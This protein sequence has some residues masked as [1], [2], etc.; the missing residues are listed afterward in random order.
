M[1]CKLIAE[2]L[3]WYL[4]GTLAP[5]AQ[6]QT[7]AHLARCP[8]C[9]RELQATVEAVH[10][11]SQHAPEEA[12]LDYAFNQPLAA[13]QR[14]LLERHLATCAACAEQLE[15][16]RESCR[17][18]EIEVARADQVAAP[19][20]APVADL[21]AAR[22]ARARPLRGWQYGALAASLLGCIALGGW[23]WHWQQARQSAQ[24]LASLTGQQRELQERLASLEAEN[25]QLRQPEPQ[26]PEPRAQQELAQLRARVRE[27]SVPQLN[28]V[29]LD[30][31]P[32]EMA[33]RGQSSAVN[34]LRIPAR[35]SALTLLLN[36]QSQQAARSYSLE[37]LDAQQR[38]IAS[39]A[40]LARQATGDY[41][42][43]LPAALL[44]PGR[45]TFNVYGQIAG[46]RV[47]VDSYQ[48]Q[49]SRTR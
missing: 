1:D 9:Q 48:I 19:Q 45:Y 16:V 25:R 20:P 23:L 14:A 36:S 6:Q 18:G 34:Q 28:V 42:L 11:Y 15:L 13:S 30:V 3:P 26:Q 17:L 4:N 43:S 44:P 33:Q 38:A 40:G 32:Q 21:N 5:D 49:L 22:Q 41:T 7:Q 35:A 10:I 29:V 31:Y 24:L 46:K 47:K 8:Q 27:L 2:I 12:L 39:S 37:I